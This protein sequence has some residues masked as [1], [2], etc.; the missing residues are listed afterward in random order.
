MTHRF[1]DKV[2]LVT[3]GNSGIG[4]STALAFAREGAKVVIAARRISEGEGTV[5]EIEEAGGEAFFVRTDVTNAEEVEHLV[6]MTIQKYGRLDYA[7]NNAGG[8]GKKSAPVAEYPLEDWNT[9]ISVNL[10]GVWLCMKYEIPEMLKNG[11]GVIVNNSSLFGLRGSSHGNSA[12]TAS[13]HGVIGL[14]KAAAL[15]YAHA[16]IRIIAVCPGWI[17]TPRIVS[18]MREDPRFEALASKVP[19][20]RMGKP[21]EIAE[22]VVWL[23]SGASSY[24]TGSIFAID[25]G[26]LAL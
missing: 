26:V 16:G 4:R 1:E 7:F 6:R 15:E 10:T 25:G 21:E 2:V 12:Y 3:G 8:G 13:K 20:G 17:Q 22:A 24:V 23:C 11:G 14:T 5:Q 19:M 18:Y 9:V